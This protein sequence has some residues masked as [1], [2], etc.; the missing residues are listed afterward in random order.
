MMAL[1]SQ[2]AGYAL[3][4]LVPVLAVAICVWAFIGLWKATGRTVP[5]P[6]FLSRE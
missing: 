5:L 1:F 3:Y 6:R 2:Y 4:L